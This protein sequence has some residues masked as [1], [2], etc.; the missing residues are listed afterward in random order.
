MWTEEKLKFKRIFWPVLMMIF[1]MSLS[2]CAASSENS[3]NEDV[4]KA[5]SDSD[6]VT[7]K[8]DETKKQ[9]ETTTEKVTEAPTRPKD[10]VPPTVQ[11][12][13]EREI[14]LKA[15]TPY[16]EAGYFATDNLEGD[17]TAKVSVETGLNIYIAGTYEIHY[18]ARD[19]DGNE[20]F[21][22]RTVHITPISQTST[23]PVDGKIIYLTFDDGPGPYTNKLLDILDKYNVKA[24]F[25][26]CYK[27]AFDDAL[28]RM[29]SSGHSLAIHSASHRYNDIYAS[30][31]AFF[32]DITTVRNHIKNVTGVDTTLMRFPGGSSNGVSK[33]NPGIM[34]RL[35]K[36]VTDMGYQY[37]DWN[38][39]SGDAA[40]SETSEQV[41]GSVVA[42]ISGKKV[43]MVLQHD[44][45]LFSVDAVEQ[46]I[47][48]GIANGYTFLPIDSTTPP[49]HHKVGN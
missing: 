7:D 26:L 30:E 46:I 44:I 39:S 10:T 40:G 19:E 36:A 38:V 23:V 29:A 17:I 49:V 22:V 2:G 12:V 37:F 11:L 15:G 48:W 4:V 41:F 9:P 35:T 1:V 16:T 25:F 34:T 45:K 8:E 3:E 18:I 27:P 32:N 5:E 47:T 20:A 14:T 13:G 31:E 6:L 43:A 33:F 24:T 28:R 21:A 42:G